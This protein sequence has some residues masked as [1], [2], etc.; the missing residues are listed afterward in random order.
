V[1]AKKSGDK[2]TL[3]VLR[4]GKEENL[5]VTLG[6]RPA[7]EQRPAFPGLPGGRPP[8]FLGI[9]MQPGEGGVVVSEVVPNSPAARAG[10]R[11]DDVITAVDDRPTNNPD[12]LRDAIQK[13]GPGKEVTLQVLRGKE[14]QTIKTTL[15]EGGAGFFGAPGENRFPMMDMESMFDQGR[16][17][18]ELE[19]RV[20]ELEKRLKELEKK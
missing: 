5:A 7:Q 6:E 9:Q 4:N 13:A 20:S 18:R 19:R 1:A 3:G 14:K 2:V 12:D 8:A 17:L 15:G 11:R 10:L 16:R